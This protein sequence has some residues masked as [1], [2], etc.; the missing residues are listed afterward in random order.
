VKKVLLIYS[1]VRPESWV[2][3][4]LM[5]IASNLRQ[6]GIDVKIV[7]SKFDDVFFEIDNFNPDYIGLGGMTVMS[8]HAVNLGLEIK[9][10]RPD[11]K[12]VYGGVHF[13]FLPDDAKRV[14]D[15]I[16]RGEGEKVYLDICNGVPL[17]SIP[18]I[19]YK[20]NNEWIDNGDWELIRNL[21]TL[22]FPAYDLIDVNRY[23][24]ELVTGEKA[25]SIMTGRGCPYLCTF[26]ASPKL[27][28]RKTRYHSIDYTIKHIQYLIDN[29]DLKNLR[30]MDDTFT[31]SNKRVVDFC[32]A[33]KENNIKLKMTC[34]TNV[35][36]ADFDTFKLMHDVGFDIVAFGLESVDRNVLKLAKKNNTREKMERAVQLAHSAGLRTELLFMVG[37][38][39]ETEKSLRD[40]LDFSKKLNGYKVYF[41]LATPFPGSVFYD[42]A[43]KYGTVVDRKWEQYNHK[44]IKYIPH[45]L[46][47]EAMYSA[48]KEGIK[49]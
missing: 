47:E 45:G 21:D 38:M 6:N 28:K 36:N 29:Y 8:H 5:Y 43:E 46:S 33:I 35:N 2:P 9:S 14:A 23:S 3:I 10:M 41:Q 22:P 48:V 20:K 4:G 26:C 34:L 19:L 15:I 27:W 30:I 31:C 37:N 24:D 16:V 25:I 13:T 17:D 44:E 32:N 40:S 42:D 1:N 49:N 7:D 39:G 18:G 11:I 12:L